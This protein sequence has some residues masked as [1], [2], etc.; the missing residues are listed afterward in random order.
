MLVYQ[1]VLIVMS[2][3]AICSLVMT[4]MTMENALFIDDFPSYNLLL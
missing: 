4:D 2:V 1:R 3:K